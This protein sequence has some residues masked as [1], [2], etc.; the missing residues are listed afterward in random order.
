MIIIVV[1]TAV[2]GLALMYYILNSKQSKNAIETKAAAKTPILKRRSFAIK[3]KYKSFSEVQKALRKSGLES[4]NLIIGIDFTKSNMWT[5]EETFGGKS[6]HFLAH[7]DASPPDFDDDYST[8]NLDSKQDMPPSFNSQ[9]SVGDDLH[10]VI[11]N[12]YEHAI[13][14]LGQVLESFDDDNIIPTYGFGDIRTK[15]KSVFPLHDPST[16]GLNG[17]HQVIEAYHRVV[18]TLKFSGPT[19]FVPLIDKAIEHTKND[20]GYHI[21][22]IIA[23]GQVSRQDVNAEAIVR[24]S[25]HPLSIIMVGVGD[26]PWEEMRAFDDALPQR[27]FDNFQ[28]VPFSETMQSV[29]NADHLFALNTLMELPDQYKTIRQLNLLR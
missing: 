28:F 13:T 21:L 6:L 9:A 11:M 18:P 1:A 22:L 23:D 2:L 19:S 17:F 14:M 20:G 24:A 25:N 12:P 5:G 7:K 16:G 4:S 15:D 10:A 26:G 29:N 3:D 8:D 27:R